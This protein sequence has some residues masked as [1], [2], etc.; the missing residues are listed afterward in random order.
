MPVF[1]IVALLVFVAVA[2]GLR[3]WLHMRS[4]GSS[5]FVG[6]RPG[7][8][9]LER[10]A[11]VAMVLSFALVPIGV[12]LGEPVL[13]TWTIAS[14][15]VLVVLGT[16]GTFAA[17]LDMRDSWRIGVDPAARTELVTV[18]AFR[19]V[20]NPIFTMMIGASI[21]LALMCST[22]LMLVLP[23][24]LVLALE[25]QVR[26]VE[27]PWLASVHGD[28]YRAWASRTGRFVPGLGRMRPPAPC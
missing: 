12:W 28:A 25:L 17:Q 21:G 5:G 15:V 2:F 10:I 19:W 27:E 1:T 11:G 20:R 4:T 14:G 26:L 8:G 9:A 23:L 22:P 7:A 18:G 3:T 6:I 16:V 13:P 24:V